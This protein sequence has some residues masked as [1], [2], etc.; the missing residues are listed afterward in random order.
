MSN[1]NASAN[2]A[3]SPGGPR[4]P[5]N[6]FVADGTTTADTVA[7]A[8]PPTD[9]A[10]TTGAAAPA[11]QPVA[12]AKS[13]PGRDDLPLS[14]RK[15]EDKEKDNAQGLLMQESTKND[16]MLKQ[17][18]G[19][20]VQS[21]PMNQRN[22]RQYRS[23]ENI[24]PNDSRAK[25]ASKPA[26]DSDVS[27]GRKV[28]SGRTFERKDGVWYETSYQGHPT[29]NVRRGTDEFK[30]LDAGLRAIANSLSGTI[31]VVWGSKAYRIQ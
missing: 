3:T 7:A 20:N 2:T 12:P 1:S 28:V 21:G 27:G 17:Q 10:A 19:N 26:M 31:V 5:E 23:L 29:I 6:N 14:A 22:E 4:E 16:A 18:A 25:R 30:R 9:A 24:S 13:L 15:L 8:P 11:A